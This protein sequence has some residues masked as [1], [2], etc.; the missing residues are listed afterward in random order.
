MLPSAFEVLIQISRHEQTKERAG[1]ARASER[2]S[3][4]AGVASRRPQV[5]AA[6]QTLC[7]SARRVRTSRVEMVF[8][9]LIHLGY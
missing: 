9:S 2:E 7:Y 6:S 3:Q 8:K 4:W 1:T 5:F